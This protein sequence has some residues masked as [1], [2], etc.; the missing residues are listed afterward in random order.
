M[1]LLPIKPKNEVKVGI[2]E[3]NFKKL[4]KTQIFNF[5]F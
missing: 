1:I 2:I 3:K 4:R 5:Q